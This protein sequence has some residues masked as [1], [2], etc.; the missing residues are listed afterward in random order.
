MNLEVDVIPQTKYF[1]INSSFMTR[2][3]TIRSNRVYELNS[4]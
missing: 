3:T 2:V 1:N 4:I